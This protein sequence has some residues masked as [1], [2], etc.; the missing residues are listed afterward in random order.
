MLQA[1]FRQNLMARLSTV[2]DDAAIVATVMQ[3]LDAVPAT[4]A[5]DPAQNAD[6]AGVL[7]IDAWQMEE[8]ARHVA[9][10][11]PLVSLVVWFRLVFFSCSLVV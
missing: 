10:P 3:T 8:T 4:L 5:L 1:M 6:L 7:D 11:L 2:F 9:G